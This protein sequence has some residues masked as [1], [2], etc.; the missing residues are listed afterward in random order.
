MMIDPPTNLRK[1]T[2]HSARKMTQT[3]LAQSG[4]SWREA[5][6]EKPGSATGKYV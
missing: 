2:L 6:L 5:F 4:I 1:I 3:I